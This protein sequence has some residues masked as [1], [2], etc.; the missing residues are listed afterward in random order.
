MKLIIAG[1][2]GFE[3]NVLAVKSFMALIAE[4]N[5]TVITTVTQT[6]TIAEQNN[7]TKS[8][9]VRENPFTE[10]VISHT[11]GDCHIGEFVANFYKIPV[12]RFISDWDTLGKRAGYVRN[13][14]MVEYA[15]ALLVF[16][17]G[18]SRCTE[19]VINIAKQK[20]LLVKVVNY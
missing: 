4:V 2:R 11:K 7:D 16:W 9:V 18:Q 1:G 13:V 15:D 14:E 5:Y 10:I 20:G 19:H 17:D 3:D 8:I 12:K 6:K